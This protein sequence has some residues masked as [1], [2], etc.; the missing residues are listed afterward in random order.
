MTGGNDPER[1]AAAALACMP[2]ITPARLAALFDQWGTARAALA[3]VRAGDGA[4]IACLEGRRTPLPEAQRIAAR[5]RTIDPDAVVARCRARGTRVWLD[6]DECFPI[7]DEVPDRPRVLFGEGERFD[8]FDAPRVAIVGTR[9]ATPSGLADTERLAGALA[10]AG[11][12]VVSGLAIGIDGAAHRGA[13]TAGGAT[14]AVVATGCDVVYPR[15]HAVL[16]EQVLGHGVIVTESGFGVGPEPGRFPVRN[17]IIAALADVVVI[18]EATERGGARITAEHALEYGRTVLAMP[19]SRRN[20]AAAGCNALVADG[21][22]PLLAPSDVF[23][24]LGLDA[25]TDVE[26]VW[27]SAPPAHVSAAG[28]AVLAAIA[29]AGATLDELCARTDRS[30]ATLSATLRDLEAA[31]LARRERGRWWPV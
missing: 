3:A 23:L 6:R 29:D 21:A 17:R 4:V 1:R 14:V 12:T 26:S 13:I 11:I 2:G 24:A 28:R 8:A 19:G 27:D 15:R 18:T 16:T 30:P 9:A 7:Q 10:A 20:P 25:P 5:W 31:G 22:H